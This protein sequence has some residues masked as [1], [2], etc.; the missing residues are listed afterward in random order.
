MAAAGM[1]MIAGASF[2]YAE[3]VTEAASEETA[4]MTY[5]MMDA[6]L[7]EGSWLTLY[8]KFDLFIPDDWEDLEITEEQAEYGVG[9]IAAAPVEDGDEYRMNVV[10]SAAQLE[11]GSVSGLEDLAAQLEEAGNEEVE[12]TTING[13]PMVTYI[14]V[15]G[16]GDAF[17]ATFIDGE[18]MIMYSVMIGPK[19]D[20]VQPYAVNIL[21]S[22]SEPEA[23]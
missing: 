9:Y 11:D 15:N 20:E 7:Y 21:L 3:A 12:I 2:T 16:N 5:E 10:V 14:A 18:E 13:I 23:K 4:A 1:M 6:D 17:S 8:E 19:T 22:I